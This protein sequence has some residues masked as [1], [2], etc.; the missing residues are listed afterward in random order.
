MESAES[1]E[2][3]LLNSIGAAIE[4]QGYKP[5]P[6]PKVEVQKRDLFDRA[7]FVSIKLGRPGIR[8]AV[9]SAKVKFV[10]EGEYDEPQLGDAEVD[11]EKKVDRE[12]IAVSK[13]L[14]DC[15][16]YKDIVTLDRKIKRLIRLRCIPSVVRRGIFLLSVGLVNEVDKEVQSFSVKRKE[17][18]EAYKAVY[19]QRVNEAI[20]RLGPEGNREDYPAWETI[21]PMFTFSF[22]YFSLGAPTMLGNVSEEIFKR[23]Q[24]RVAAQFQSALEIGQ[25]GLYEM[26]NKLVS[27]ITKKLTVEPGEKQRALG[28]SLIEQ[29][30]DFCRV[31]DAQNLANDQDL[32]AL[33]EKAKNLMDGVD[34]KDTSSRAKGAD[35]LRDSIKKGMD[36]ISSNLGALIVERPTRAITFDD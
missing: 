5:T 20:E 25:Q 10:S 8:K 13:K 29:L 11:G 1:V 21:E 2:S 9:D 7:V 35:V 34:S 32:K 33:V 30:N 19:A 24:E 6:E 27:E 16:E 4:G 22:Q 31:F 12:M 28:S 15:Q 18:V 36:E 17:L 3:S 26:F 14:I 23:E